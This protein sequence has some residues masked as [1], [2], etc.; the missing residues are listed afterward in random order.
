VPNERSRRGSALIEV[1]VALLLLAISGTALITLLGQTTRSIV[2]VFA[3]ERQ[4][5]DAAAQL[6][7]LSTLNRSDLIGRTGRGY[8]RGW[9]LAVDRANADLFDVSI[10]ASDTGMV[11]LRT[12]LYRPEVP[13][14]TTP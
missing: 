4:T 8:V 7:R 2:T 12:T 14:D 6:T 1:L 9:W 13:N 10:A 5:R 3:T 11:L